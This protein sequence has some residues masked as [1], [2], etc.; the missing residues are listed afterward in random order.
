M[1]L[2]IFNNILFKTQITK[3]RVNNRIGTMMFS[4]LVR[5]KQFIFIILQAH[6]TIILYLLPTKNIL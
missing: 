1:H 5:T 2:F 4:S 3:L 6:T